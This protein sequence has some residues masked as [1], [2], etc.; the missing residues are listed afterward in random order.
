M[1]AFDKALSEL[2]VQT[3]ATNHAHEAV[4]VGEP[5]DGPPQRAQGGVPGGHGHA[6]PRRVERINLVVGKRHEGVPRLLRPP[7]VHLEPAQVIRPTFHVP[8]SPAIR[9]GRES[10]GLL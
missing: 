3:E 2:S 6:P 4:V 10:G 5:V 7:V 9:G 8:G 1:E